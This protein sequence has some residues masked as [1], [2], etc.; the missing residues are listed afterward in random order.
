MADPDPL[1]EGLGILG[2]TPRSRAISE[3][4]GPLRRA[5]SPQSEI[6][7]DPSQLPRYMLGLGSTLGGNVYDIGSMGASA[8]G[9][10][11][12]GGALERLAQ[13]SYDVG[14]SFEREGVMD[15]L[16]GGRSQEP[17]DSFMLPEITAYSDD[18]MIDYGDADPASI[19]AY[20]DRLSGPMRPKLPSAPEGEMGMPSAPSLPERGAAAPMGEPPAAEEAPEVDVKKGQEIAIEEGLK[21][22]IDEYLAALGD[23]AVAQPKSIDEYKDIFAQATGIDISGKP[24]KSQALMA[25]GLA[26]MQNRAGKGF[27]V[28]NM[29]RSIGEAGEAA[30]PALAEARKEA[31]AGQLAAGQYALGQL[32]EAQNSARATRVAAGEYALEQLQAGRN[33]RAALAAEQRAFAEEAFLKQMELDSEAG[34]EAMKLEAERGKPPKIE[35]VSTISPV[36]GLD[37]RMGSANG[38]SVFANGVPAANVMTRAYNSAQGALGTL[39]EIEA[40]INEIANSPS[41]SFTLLADRLNTSLA[42]LG[43]KDP[44]VSFGED[45]VS[46]EQKATA[47][48]DSLI[49]EFKR[50]L[51]QETGNGI[52]NVDVQNM[53]RLLGQMNILGNPQDAINR[54]R[55]V[56]GIFEGK[57]SGLNPFIE[58]LQDPYFFTSTEEFDKVQGILDEKLGTMPG[59]QIEVADGVPTIDLTGQ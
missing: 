44:K 13:E 11:G 38:R 20:L 47:L 5:L 15:T 45:G 51:T 55:Q 50:F 30:M 24:D 41:P 22:G 18:S 16:L 27:N 32:K 26:L 3:A 48:R 1:E 25:F 31:R 23:D 29:L 39:N 21:A 7:R 37:I 28:G 59:Y 6:L 19:Q 10:P 14:R 56:R 53:E 40:S 58:Q 42:G 2:A 33:A 54:V 35:N 9:L 57:V 4:V 52:S 49:Q 34:I 17:T 12:V 46:P 8:L 43:L 36:A